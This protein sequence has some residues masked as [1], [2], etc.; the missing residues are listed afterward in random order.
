LNTS[1]NFF[2]YDNSS[3]IKKKKIDLENANERK[4]RDRKKG[5]VEK[6]LGKK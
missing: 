1:S 4:K 5:E 6:A 3:Q 2:K